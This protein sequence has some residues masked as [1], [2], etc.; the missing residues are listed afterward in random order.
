VNA[1]AARI[2]SQYRI[3]FVW[4]AP[5]ADDVEIVDDH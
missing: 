2:N 4:A 1:G 3:C 5:D